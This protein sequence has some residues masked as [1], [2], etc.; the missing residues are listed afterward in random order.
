MTKLIVEALNVAVVSDSSKEG[1]QPNQI[2]V[3]ASTKSGGDG[4]D[5]AFHFLP[6]LVHVLLLLPTL[7]VGLLSYFLH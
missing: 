6:C 3:V 4:G 1:P 7:T 2:L 5:D